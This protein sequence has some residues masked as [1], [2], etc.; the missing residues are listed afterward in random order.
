MKITIKQATAVIT[1]VAFGLTLAGGLVFLGIGG[2]LVFAR[3]RQLTD[4]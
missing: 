3:R 2:M 1:T 4:N